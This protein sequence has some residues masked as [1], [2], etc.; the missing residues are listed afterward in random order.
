MQAHRSL[1]AR[2]ETLDLIRE[3]AFRDRVS[4]QSLYREGLLLMLRQRGY[5]LNKGIDDV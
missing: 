5:F 1:Y 3:I 2:P 4:A